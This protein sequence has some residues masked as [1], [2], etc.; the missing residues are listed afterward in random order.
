MNLPFDPDNYIK[1]RHLLYSRNFYFKIGKNTNANN[2]FVSS[3]V[4]LADVFNYRPEEVN[5]KW[6]YDNELDAYTVVAKRNIK[7]GEEVSIV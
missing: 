3:F 5:A 7:Q 6:Y 2:T 1:A 4:P